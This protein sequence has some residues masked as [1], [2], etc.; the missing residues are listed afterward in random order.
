MTASRKTRGIQMRILAPLA[1]ITALATV[2]LSACDVAID[3]ENSVY[4]VSGTVTL[5]AGTVLESTTWTA[6]L[7]SADESAK[8]IV[9]NGTM[10]GSSFK[11][12]INGIDAEGKYGLQVIVHCV[13]ASGSV[14]AA[15]G[16]YVAMYGAS[17]LAE[18]SSITAPNL[19]VNGN[20]GNVDLNAVKNAVPDTEK[21]K[22]VA[23]VSGTVTLPADLTG[24]LYVVI[25]DNGID[26]SANAGYVTGTISGTAIAYSL[27]LNAAGTY[28]IMCVVFTDGDMEGNPGAGDYVGY[29]GVSTI[30]DMMNLAPNLTVETGDTL[31]DIS[32]NALLIPSTGGDPADT[33]DS[34]DPE[35]PVDEAALMSAAKKANDALGSAW[36]ANMASRVRDNENNAYKITLQD[37]QESYSGY[38]MTG[39]ISMTTGTNA[40]TASVTLSGGNSNPKATKIECANYKAMT[41]GSLTVTFE[42]GQKYEETL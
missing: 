25:A 40:M 33:G 11:Y 18:F 17:T 42:N 41:S 3:P 10:T 37:Y 9:A 16:D 28:T 1:I 7:F 14:E 2:S 13:S 38:V 8:P 22:T 12:E 27:D 30:A 4:S 39:T 23:T 34:E 5:P 19:T 26:D 15:A 29:W 21:G 31:T 20:L 35:D 6:A 36:I 32:F 24:K